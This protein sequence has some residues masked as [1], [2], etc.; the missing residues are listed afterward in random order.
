MKILI[1]GEL[2]NL[3]KMNEL[4]KISDLGLKVYIE[5]DCT[6]YDIAVIKEAVYF[7]TGLQFEEYTTESTK[8][9]HFYARLIF[10]HQ[11]FCRANLNTR[12]ITKML[13]RNTGNHLRYLNNYD[14]EF[15][16]NKYFRCMAIKVDNFIT[17]H[18]S[19]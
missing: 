17:K 9:D 16:Y 5:K 8:R 12:E 15:K 18:V 2:C 1:T 10:A 7:I 13:N 3:D 4:I 14:K 6:K 19:H 11:A